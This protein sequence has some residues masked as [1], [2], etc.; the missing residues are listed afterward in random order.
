MKSA[1][2]FV[3]LS[4]ALAAGAKESIVFVGAH[5]D[6]SEGFAGTA[7]L[8]REKYDLHIVDVT[9][10]ERGLGV[11][12]MKDGSTGRIRVKEEEN[13]CRL[14]GATPHF[15]CEVNGSC[16]A[17]AAAAEMLADILRR[18]K[19]RAIF[20]H[21]PVDGHPDHVQ[22]A[23]LVS[24]ALYAL[25]EDRPREIR[26]PEFYFYE[27]IPGETEQFPPL[28]SVDITSTMDLKTQMMRC[29]A[30]QNDDDWLAQTKI[31]QAAERGAERV[32][33]VAYAEVFT[34]FDG[35]PIP[36]GV[37]EEWGAPLVANRTAEP[38]P[39]PNF[40]GKPFW[41]MFAKLSH[42]KAN[43]PVTNA[44]GSVGWGLDD[45]P[46]T[47]EYACN[48]ETHAFRAN[49]SKYRFSREKEPATGRRIY[50]EPIPEDER[51]AGPYTLKDLFGPKFGEFLYTGDWTT[52]RTWNPQADSP[53]LLEVEESRLCYFFDPVDRADRADFGRWL[54]RHPN[55]LGFSTLVEIDSV[56]GN[57]REAM[58]G[59]S[60]WARVPDGPM[61]D[62]MLRRFPVPE[63]R[64]GYV[65]LMR[66]CWEAEIQFH[67]GC[68]RFW[69]MYCNNHTLA[70][71][72]AANGAAGLVAETSSSQGSSWG[73]S[74]AYTRGASRQ[75]GIPFSW[76]CATF[77]RGFR[78]GAD[79]DSKLE[80]GD[81]K[82]PRDGVLTPK[83]PSYIGASLS[84]T[85]R[86]KYYGWLIGA[87]LIQD[88]A[89]TMLC[90]SK[91]NGVF[92]ASPYAKVFNDVFVRSQKI[93]RGAPYTPIALLTPLSESVYRGGH[94][95]AV[96]DGEGRL[97]DRFNLPAYLFT[98][99]PPHEKASCPRFEAD[100]LRERRLKG[101]EGC[102]FNSPYG[103]IWDVLVAD[104]RQSTD[105]FAAALRHY[106]AAFLIGT[107]RKGDVNLAALRAY[108]ENGGTL[109][110]SADYVED[111]IVPA[112]F[113][114]VSFGADRV[115]SGKKLLDAS[116]RPVEKLAGA[117]LL[118]AGEPAAGTSPLLTDECGHVVAYAH[119]LGRGR[120]ITTTCHR[121]L[122]EA[123]AAPTAKSGDAQA[124]MLRR[125]LV[126]DE[127]ELG[128]VR[129]LLTRV[130]DETIPLRVM[131]DIQWGVNF[132]EGKREEVRGKKGGW[133][134]WL[135][136]NKGIAKYVGEPADVDP[137]KAVSVQLDLRGLRGLTPYDADTGE[138]LPL[139][140]NIVTV[141][142]EPGEVRL[143]TIK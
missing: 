132:V 67:F 4:F 134:V 105:A 8:L 97:R 85:A 76:Y 121:S 35:R 66:R 77:Y 75:W 114:G 86:Q 82:W 73:W 16:H 37:L 106:P 44:N 5:P 104:S 83:R 118:H 139:W 128:L 135:M 133:L 23:A 70:H 1:L 143:I 109:F 87:G 2:W 17:S 115:T 22:T 122:P 138:P 119:A 130:Q 36:G 54:A 27:V 6:D 94:V 91:T 112:E 24:A 96:E 127:A 11:E 95:D 7:F 71:I 116:G 62:E 56:T 51:H 48:M 64:Y 49:V 69:P 124:G 123:F 47:E 98:L 68:D 40:R 57:Y 18:L 15:L 131:G 101:D 53:F 141:R 59:S 88:E 31:R 42:G 21:W 99:Q 80:C 72:H 140:G 55:F 92:C 81:N 111:G 50:A 33:P 117:Y 12:G 78:R 38:W 102:L 93:D 29:Y 84:L 10:G 45:L 41:P 9:R 100:F 3:V 113:A 20:T 74:G 90:T 126:G 63:D 108:V 137:T 25:K 89:W 136:N 129:H 107:Y 13:A 60:F 32:P 46:L 120:V 110:L 26:D 19:P 52:R 58:R 142:V 28:Y 125:Q 61:R 65:D 79:R 30:C 103:E 43:E 14:L 39:T 34:T